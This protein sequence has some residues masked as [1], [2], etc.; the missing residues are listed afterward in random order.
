MADEFATSIACPNYS[1]LLF[2]KGNTRT[3]FCSMIGGKKDGIY[4]NSTEFSVGQEYSTDGGSQPSISEIASLTAPTATV[5]KR[6]QLTNVTQIFHETVGVS[7][8]KMSNMGAMSGL[9]AADQNANPSDELAFQVAAKMA[10]IERD[11]E[12]TFLNGVYAKAASDSTAN[13]TRG[14]FPAITSNVVAAENKPL[15]IWT[16]TNAL[17]MIYGNDVPV[18]GLVAWLDAT[19]LFQL[20]ADAQN[21]GLT[22]VPNDRTING[23]QLSCVLTPLGKIYLQL[24]EFVPAGTAGIFNF[25]VIKPKLQNV[26]EKG[27]FF[28]E[29]LS[30]TGAGEKYQIF[31][32]AGLDH[33]PEWFHA[34]ITGLN[35][36]FTAP[37]G[38]KNV[39]VVDD[40]AGA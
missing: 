4:T 8:A 26:P 6:K 27:N 25:D 28:L 36:E 19:S 20:N 5:K 16:L 14:M 18:N 13:K 17:K 35:T 24:G 23:I 11:M 31:G 34:K 21:N 12:Y 38:V 10:K 3:P 7:Y 37:D 40:S 33:G 2:N 30:K 1:G 39:R 32:Q 9:N 22:I 15:T 29:P